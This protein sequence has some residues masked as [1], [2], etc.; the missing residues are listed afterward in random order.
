MEARA[1]IRRGVYH[2]AIVVQANDA[3]AHAR[4]AVTHRGGG[5]ADRE[6]ALGDHEAQGVG[7][8]LLSLLD[9]APSAYDPH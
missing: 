4:S 5:T 8:L 1:G 6:G 7:Q 3:V 9:D 2:G